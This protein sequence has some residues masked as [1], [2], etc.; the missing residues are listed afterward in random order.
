LNTESSGFEPHWHKNNAEQSMG[1][2]PRKE[3]GPYLP[4]HFLLA[5]M[6]VQWLE[7]KQPPWA[8]H[9]VQPESK[10]LGLWVSIDVTKPLP[11]AGLGT[12]QGGLWASFCTREQLLP[13]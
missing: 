2:T 13:F 5:G 12:L 10:A 1:V 9:E 4:F 6:Q 11:P 3:E 8:R 7:L